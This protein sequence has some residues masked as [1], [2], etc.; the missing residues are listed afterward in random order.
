MRTSLFGKTRDIGSVPNGLVTDILTVLEAYR[1]S[2]QPRLSDERIACLEAALA[3]NPQEIRSLRDLKDFVELCRHERES[4]EFDAD[5]HYDA[6]RVSAYSSQFA[7]PQDRHTRRCIYL[8]DGGAHS[9][10]ETV[11]DI[12]CGSGLS[13]RTLSGY[14]GFVIGVDASRSMLECASSV[15]SDYVLANFGHRLPFRANVFDLG[16]STSAVHYLLNHRMRLDC[17]IK[18]LNRICVGD[19]AWQLFPRGGMDDLL[20]ISSLPYEMHIFKDRPHR[21]DKDRFYVLLTRNFR[22]D[23]NC[24]LFE[25]AKCLQC[26]TNNKRAKEAEIIEQEHWDWLHREHDRFHRRQLRILN[27][28]SQ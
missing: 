17:L 3:V 22:S 4:S 14:Y 12:G 6:S 25:P 20:E 16:S 5:T 7:V 2:K 11:L 8:L 9:K 24:K 23:N 26:M 21:G 15:S 10:K 27:R 1:R 28:A 18:E 19:V 13:T